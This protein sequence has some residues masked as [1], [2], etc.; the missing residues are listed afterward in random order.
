MADT[1]SQI[2]VAVHVHRV[3]NAENERD[4]ART[5]Y[6]AAIDEA[7]AAGVPIKGMHAAMRSMKTGRAEGLS[8]DALAVVA[9]VRSIPIGEVSIC[10]LRGG[11]FPPT[12]DA[13][14]VTRNNDGATA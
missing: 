1:P 3:W 8:L 14:T 13:R 11:A 4:R 6:Q 10:P 12:H 7:R 5:A 9:A 2:A